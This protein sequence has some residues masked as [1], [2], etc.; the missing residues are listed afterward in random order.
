MYC[1]CDVHPVSSSVFRSVDDC[2]RTKSWC[3]QKNKTCFMR[4]KLLIMII[5]QESG[6]NLIRSIKWGE[7]NPNQTLKQTTDRSASALLT[8]F[9]TD[10]WKTFGRSWKSDRR[11]VFISK[12][13]AVRSDWGSAAARMLQMDY[14]YTGALFLLRFPF[15]PQLH[16]PWCG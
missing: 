12:S 8:V 1:M 7:R 6:L 11:G 4:L 13:I 5:N 15:L 3:K 10:Q 16:C 9:P 2:F 14:N